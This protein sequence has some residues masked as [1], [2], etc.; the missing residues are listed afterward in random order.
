MGG[1]GREA[2]EEEDACMHKADSCTA[3]TNS[4]VKQLSS[5]EKEKV[6]GQCCH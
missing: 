2:Q 1:G 4:I 6:M 5:S 3:G